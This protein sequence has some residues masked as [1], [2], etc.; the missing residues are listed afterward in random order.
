MEEELLI[1]DEIHSDD[2]QSITEPFISKLG[3]NPDPVIH[4]P[5]VDSWFE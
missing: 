1:Q 3:N 4:K 2:G 5:M